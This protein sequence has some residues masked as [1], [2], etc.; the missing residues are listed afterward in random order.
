VAYSSAGDQVLLKR[1]TSGSAAG[2]SSRVRIARAR[3]PA[4]IA[5]TTVLRG[6]WRHVSRWIG[7]RGL[8]S[9]RSAR[10]RAVRLSKGCGRSLM[11]GCEWLAMWRPSWSVPRSVGSGVLASAISSGINSRDRLTD[12]TP[13]RTHDKPG[14]RPPMARRGTSNRV[15]VVLAVLFTVSGFGGCSSNAVRTAK[16]VH[17]RV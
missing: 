5:I 14:V 15:A 17:D 4:S 13:A 1:G 3:R 8:P 6:C 11:Q 16:P 7:R 9:G 2:A 10:R 12:L